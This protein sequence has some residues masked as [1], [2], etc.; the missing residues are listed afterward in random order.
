MVQFAE[1]AICV[2]WNMT[3]SELLEQRGVQLERNKKTGELQLKLQLLRGLHKANDYSD[4]VL[5]LSAFIGIRKRDPECR[6]KVHMTVTLSGGD[7]NN[8]S[9]EMSYGFEDGE[10]E[11]DLTVVLVPLEVIKRNTGTRLTLSTTTQLRVSYKE[12]YVVVGMPEE[13]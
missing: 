6:Y 1:P 2:E 4:R 7:L 11:T 5:I 12:D 13:N 10:K 9:W 8:P 3:G